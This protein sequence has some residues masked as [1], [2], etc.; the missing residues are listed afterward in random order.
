MRSSTV[1]FKKPSTCISRQ[2]SKTCYIKCST[3]LNKPARGTS[4]LLLLL[5]EWV[6]NRVTATPLSSFTTAAPESDIFESMS[7]IFSSLLPLQ[8]FVIHYCI[9]QCR[10]RHDRSRKASLFPWHHDQIQQCWSVSATKDICHGDST[11]SKHVRMQLLHHSSG[12]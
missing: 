8:L 1:I 10:I 9:S 7:T 6:S 12:C 4:D 11:K 2:V 3:A 5:Y